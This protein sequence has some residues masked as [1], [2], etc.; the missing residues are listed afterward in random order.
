M[1]RRAGRLRP[2]ARNVR[3]L[4]KLA[5]KMNNHLSPSKF[6]I[7][8]PGNEAFGLG[9]MFQTYRSLTAQSTKTVGVFRSLA[10]AFTFLGDRKSPDIE[11]R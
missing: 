5:A 10:E 7:V 1:A 4:A 11:T 3:Q 6:A 9:R 2:P 8:A